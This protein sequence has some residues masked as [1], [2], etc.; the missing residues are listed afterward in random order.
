MVAYDAFDLLD[1]QLNSNE[2]PLAQRFRA[3]FTLKGLG[4]QRAIE[5]IGKGTL[6]TILSL[7]LTR[8]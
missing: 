2:T 4:G 8:S 7:T 6:S 3:L 5:I 1:Q